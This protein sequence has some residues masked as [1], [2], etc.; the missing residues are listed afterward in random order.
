M[1]KNLKLSVAVVEGWP[2][3][4]YYVIPI[5][6]VEN[7]KKAGSKFTIIIQT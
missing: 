2:N 5:I 7:K 4:L 3:N 1:S 6:K